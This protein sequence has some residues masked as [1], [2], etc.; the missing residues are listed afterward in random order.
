MSEVSET[1]AN[2][3]LISIIAGA[4]AIGCLVGLVIKHNQRKPLPI[5]SLSPAPAKDELGAVQTTQ[6]KKKGMSTTEKVLLSVFVVLAVVSIVTA[7]V[8]I[9]N[10][11]KSK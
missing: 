6:E 3:I 9:S 7:G 8:Y 10:K 5:H 4:A 2:I 11:N 1:Q